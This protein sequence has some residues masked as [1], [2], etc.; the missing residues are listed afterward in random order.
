MIYVEEASDIK[1]EYYLGLVF[2]RVES[3]MVV[4]SS[5]GG[6]SIQIAKEKPE[7][8]IRAKLKPQ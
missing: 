3:I 1:K 5:E 2:D 6:M 4:A 7:S 8:I